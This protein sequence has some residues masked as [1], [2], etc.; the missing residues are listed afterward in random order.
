MKV[1]SAKA[2]DAV[3]RAT[4]LLSP[5]E[6]GEPDLIWQCKSV[7][8]RV[9]RDELPVPTLAYYLLTQILDYSPRAP[10]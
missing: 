10:G 9:S 2:R 3:M 7:K 5:D 1:I 8:K 4:R 6:P